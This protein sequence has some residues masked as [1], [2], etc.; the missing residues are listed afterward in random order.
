MCGFV[1]GCWVQVIP[2]GSG[3]FTYTIQNLFAS[4]TYYVRLYAV[5]SIGRSDAVVA[6]VSHPHRALKV[7]VCVASVEGVCLSRLCPQALAGA[8]FFCAACDVRR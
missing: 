2:S 5:N 8:P 6:E 3:T 1:G 4:S 7:W